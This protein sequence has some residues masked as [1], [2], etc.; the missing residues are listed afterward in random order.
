MR[1]PGWDRRIERASEMAAKHPAAAE[2]LN[3][4][5]QLLVFQRGEYDVFASGE[6]EPAARF[7]GLLEFVQGC[8]PVPLAEYARGLIAAPERWDA[9]LNHFDGSGTPEEVFFARTIYQPYMEFRATQLGAVAAE[10]GGTC[11]F[12]TSKPVVAVLRGEGEGG[13]RSL[14]CSLCSTEWVYRRIL[15]PGCGEE[16]REKLPV[17]GAA[18]A[19]AVRIEACE[20]CHQYIK[21]VDMTKDGNAVP[22]VDDIATIA[23]DLWAQEHGYTRLQSNLLGI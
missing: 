6:Q 5:R 7:S 13:K 20:A 4:F 21:S 11:P 18:G 15:C 2:L 19:N 10:M 3:F 22:V 8:A 16:D 23:L 1:A 12:C 17:F 9:V 14:I